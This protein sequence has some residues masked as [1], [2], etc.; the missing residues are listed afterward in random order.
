MKVVFELVG[1]PLD[2][3]EIKQD[4]DTETCAF[5]TGHFNHHYLYSRGDE[6]ADYGKLLYSGIVAV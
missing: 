6:P 2:G 3:T 4:D 5:P 1:G